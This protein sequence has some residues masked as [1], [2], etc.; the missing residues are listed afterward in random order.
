[1]Q[2]ELN[3]Q[4]KKRITK[5][6]LFAENKDLANFDVMQE[7]SDS[8][9]KLAGAETV[10]I[11]GKQGKKGDKGDKGDKGERGEKGTDGK[12]GRDGIDGKDG[13]DGVNGINGINGKDGRD[14]IDGLDGKDGEMGTIDDATIAY[15]QDEITKLSKRID[16]LRN[17]KAG[18]RTGW[19]AHP[20]QIQS[21]GV[22]KEKV[23]RVINFVGTAVN[24]VVRSADGVVTVSLTAG[25]AGSTVY[26]ETPGGLINGSNVDYTTANTIT[27]VQMLAINGQFIHPSEYTV[28]GAGF[29][30]GTALD[31]SLSGLSFTIVY[32]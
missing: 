7:I 25:G 3:Q 8:L 10:R 15:L 5:V 16:E 21:A 22:I 13:K 31:A 12:D 2:P 14:G 29:T 20:L 27:T 1:M 6:G 28:T 24:S 4:Q 11:E 26:N 18:Q 19:G 9:E 17:G 23:A 30:M 32:V